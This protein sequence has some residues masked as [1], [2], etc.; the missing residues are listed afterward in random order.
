MEDSLA[1]Q[2]LTQPRL[3]EQKI[4]VEALRSLSR[5]ARL[6]YENGYT[7]YITVLDAERSLFNAEL[8]YTQTQEHLFQAL[9]NL[10][11][12]MGGGWRHLA[13]N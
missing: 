12:A 2:T 3:K 7:D 13:G 4:Q 9:A 6:R 10:Y 11:K 8:D 1:D 5:V